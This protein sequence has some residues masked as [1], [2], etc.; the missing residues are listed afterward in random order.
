MKNGKILR[1]ARSYQSCTKKVSLMVYGI[2][3]FLSKIL[4][5]GMP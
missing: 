3:S 5:E 4:S 1:K 2:P